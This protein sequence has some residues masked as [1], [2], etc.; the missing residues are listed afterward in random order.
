MP[1]INIQEKSLKFFWNDISKDI[2][3][4]FAPKNKTLLLHLTHKKSYNPHVTTFT[5]ND[6]PILKSPL[7]Q[8]IR[9][10]ISFH[11]T[12]P[13]QFFLKKRT[14]S[15]EIISTPLD[16]IE[17]LKIRRKSCNS[18][19]FGFETSFQKK[20]NSLLFH[21]KYKPKIRRENSTRVSRTSV[22]KRGSLSISALVKTSIF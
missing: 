7:A 10:F 16:M 14:N 8:R 2:I 20:S 13:K 19:I 4:P 12:L 5:K 22:M 6:K 3:S 15:F 1:K 21:I 17:G 18:K 9:S 11:E